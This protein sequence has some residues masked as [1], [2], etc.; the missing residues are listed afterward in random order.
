MNT[1]DKACVASSAVVCDIVMKSVTKLAG[2]QEISDATKEQ[3]VDVT[4]TTLTEEAG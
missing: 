1:L 2:S 3:I 4:L